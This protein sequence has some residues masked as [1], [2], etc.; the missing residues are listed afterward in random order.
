MPITT[1][2][3][4]RY[5]VA[6]SLFRPTTLGRAIRRLGFVQA[7]PIRA[8]A[9]A[10]DLTLRHRVV[11]YRAGELER[12]YPRLA[13][14]ED[15]FVNYGFLPRAN[16]AL[17][18]PRTARRAWSA[19]AAAR[20]TR[21]SSSYDH[22]ARRIRARST[23]SS[24]MARQR[25]GSAARRRRARSCWTRCTTAG[26]CGSSGAKVERGFTPFDGRRARGCG[27]GHDRGPHGC[28]RRHRGI[29]YAPLPARSLGY[30]LSLL[31]T[32]VPQ[33]RA[34][35]AGTLPRAKLRLPHA[36]IGARTG[37]GR[38]ARNIPTSRRWCPD[39]RCDCSRRSTRSCMTVIG[40][41]CFWGWALPIRG[42]HAG[43]EADPRVLRAAAAVARPGNRLGQPVDRGRQTAGARSATQRASSPATP[44]F[45]RALPRNSSECASSWARARLT[46]PRCGNCGIFGREPA[47]PHV[48]V[49][50][51]PLVRELPRVCDAPTHPISAHR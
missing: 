4:R 18:H 46:A 32:G 29:K 13:I 16:S 11:D 1:E 3:L 39:D 7:D 47:A 9:R 42:L 17:M 48:S 45:A 37:T 8:P 20:P 40:S 25:T 36:R 35:R 15:F 50:G 26:C 31:C 33:W 30:Y 12:R 19:P 5:A 24:R 34:Q 10:Q 22:A 38:T 6:R 14:E 44:R 43:A 21:Y 27:Q 41:S 51:V 2:Q 28:A 49:T 23:P